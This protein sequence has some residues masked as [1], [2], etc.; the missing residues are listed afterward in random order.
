MEQARGGVPVSNDRR[1]IARL[2]L[3]RD[4]V[5]YGILSIWRGKFAGT[6]DISREKP[7][8]K[9][10]TI[11]LFDA[12]KSWGLG[13]GFLSISIESEREP[14]QARGGQSSQTSS[15]DDAPYDNLEGE[16]PF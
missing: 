7:S 14:Y 13:E 11:G 2:T 4:R 10:Q 15:F 12:L 6:Y 8:D 3:R 9:R 5:T 1:P 16:I